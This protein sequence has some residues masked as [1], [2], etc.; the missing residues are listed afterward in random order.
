VLD[1]YIANTACNGKRGSHT[2]LYLHDLRTVIRYLEFPY[3]RQSKQ[4]AVAAGNICGTARV[5][6]G[7]LSVA[8]GAI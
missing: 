2:A 4:E 7:G 8:R 1:T 6:D 3:L 5:V